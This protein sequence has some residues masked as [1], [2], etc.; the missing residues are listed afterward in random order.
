MENHI[1]LNLIFKLGMAPIE[2]FLFKVVFVGGDF[3]AC[4]S[5]LLGI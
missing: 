1:I 5:T 3:E 4:S 2:E